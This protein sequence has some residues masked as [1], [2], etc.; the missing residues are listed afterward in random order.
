MQ[1][2]GADHTHA[3]EPPAYHIASVGRALTLLCAFTERRELTVSEAAVILDVAPSTAH[4]LLQMLI[5]HDFVVQGDRREYRPGPALA[6]FQNA[7][8][9]QTV[10]SLVLPHLQT[11]RDDL[12]GTAH[13]L[14][15]EGNGARFV[16][17]VEWH[18]PT[19]IATTRI[20]WLL[21]AHTLAGGKAMLA[22]LPNRQIDSLYPDGLPVTRYGRLRSLPQLRDE[23]RN[24]R[25][26]GYAL[27]REAHENICAIGVAVPVPAGA[28]PMAIS[29]AWA[30][31]GFSPSQEEHAV[32][33]ISGAV[34][35]VADRMA[36]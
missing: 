17:G 25:R 7:P 12:H 2:L 31:S 24:I 5:H 10:E 36:V 20:G 27:S 15:L 13:L 19:R 1:H 8:R 22:Q 21:P 11:L 32:K 9:P 29:V 26:R 18:E 6:A 23:L 3:G 28:Q 35:T 4:R 30:E 16:V 34:N 14:A 33:L